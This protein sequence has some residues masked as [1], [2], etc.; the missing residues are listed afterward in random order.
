[1]DVHTPEKRSFNM[2]RIRDRDT[3]PEMLVRRWLWANGYRYRLHK[4]DL[5]GKPDI[6]LPAYCATIFVHGCYWHRHG[7]RMTTTPATRQKFWLTKFREN[8]E[9]DKRN[10]NDLLS[11]GWRVMIIWECSLRG[12]TAIPE[13][14]FNQ[15]SNFLESDTTL[16]TDINQTGGGPYE[17]PTEDRQHNL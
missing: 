8:T 5:P 7:C 16:V 9:R 17:K 2:S 13:T 1:M 6:V 14:V 4:K 11:A 10:L 15:I 3:R 12:K